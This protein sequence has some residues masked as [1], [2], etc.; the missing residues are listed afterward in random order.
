MHTAQHIVE[1]CLGGSLME[2]R[3]IIL[4]THHISLCIPR[5]SYLVE[6]KGGRIV[7]QGTIKDLQDAGLLRTVIDSEDDISGDNKVKVAR[8]TERNSVD[9]HDGP[10]WRRKSSK[11]GKLVEAEH[12]AEGRVSL[13]T[14]MKY[15]DILFWGDDFCDDIIDFNSTSSRRWLDSLDVYHYYDDSDSSD[16]G[17]KRREFYSHFLYGITYRMH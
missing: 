17:G 9:A 1:H 14:Y 3:T 13:A 4:V 16:L 8:A 15:G 2:G 12:R 10:R 6:L 5:A 11:K 7:C